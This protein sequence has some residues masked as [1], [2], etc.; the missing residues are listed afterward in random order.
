MKRVWMSGVGVRGGGV[1]VEI[2]P[3]RGS[4]KYRL[5]LGNGKEMYKKA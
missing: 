2:P 5:V 3:K 1:C 4:Y